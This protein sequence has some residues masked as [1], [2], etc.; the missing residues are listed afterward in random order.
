[1][2]II[3]KK[4]RIINFVDLLMFFLFGEKYKHNIEYYNSKNISIC[5]DASLK[6]NI[7]GEETPS[8][9]RVNINVIENSVKI[10]VDK[11]IKKK[12]FNK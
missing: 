11:R 4:N 9:S 12:Y 2:V 7:D 5:S 1:M 6:F 8:L 10:I 3:N